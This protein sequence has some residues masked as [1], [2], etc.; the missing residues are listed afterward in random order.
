MIK[1]KTKVILIFLLLTMYV[2]TACYLEESKSSVPLPHEEFSID[3]TTILEDISQGEKEIFIPLENRTPV[4]EIEY[5]PVNWSQEDYLAVANSIHE[6]A[7]SEGLSDWK[8]NSVLFYLQCKEV[9]YGSQSVYLTYFRLIEL[10]TEEYRLVHNIVV[11]PQEKIVGAWAEKYSQLT[12]TWEE[13]KVSEFNITSDEALQIAESNSGKLFRESIKN[14]CSVSI[15]LNRTYR[16][17]RDWVV[18][19]VGRD[20]TKIEFIID[21]NTGEYQINK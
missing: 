14:D 8:L 16:N 9:P 10:D 2:L 17:D 15:S 6:F 1:P 20:N 11:Q 12:A 3:P 5:V 4:I 19:Y 13:Y 7:W 18:G 21:T